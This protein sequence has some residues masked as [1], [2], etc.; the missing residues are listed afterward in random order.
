[1][2]R[3]G[4]LSAVL[5]VGMLGLLLVNA[6]PAAGRLVP[7]RSVVRC[8]ASLPICVPTAFAFGPKGGRLFYTEKDTGQIRVRDLGT[9]KDTVWTTIQGLATTGTQ[10]LLGLALDPTWLQGLE[11]RW[12]YA[13][14]TDDG[15]EDPNTPGEDTPDRNTIVRM[16]KDGSTR[17]TEELLVIPGPAESADNGG[18]L[19][20]G[21][22]GKLYAFAGDGTV[23][24]RAQDL[25][26]PAG[27]V[28]RMNRNGS[29]PSDNPFVGQPGTTKFVYSYGNRNSFGFTFDPWT[30]R[31][32]ETE[33]GP[34]C[35]D[36]INVVV[37]GGN[38]AWGP[39][40]DC[41]SL[42]TPHD[43]NRDGPAPR[44]LPKHTFVET[45]T[46]TGAAFCRGCGLGPRSR[47]DLLVASYKHR[48]ILAF[49]LNPART[50]LSGQRAVFIGDRPPITLLAGPDGRIY[51]SDPAGIRVLR[52]DLAS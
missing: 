46:P 51:F 8:R 9:G 21:P 32:W 23:P 2:G 6:G 30:G 18:P 37:L 42:P 12:V 27:K 24:S 17:I 41:G 29:A 48:R 47:R 49:D 40:H 28:L 39:S 4:V 5:V 1:M 14:Y 38:Y 13:Y 44:I 35:N 45:V 3:R 20:F 7:A 34:E 19:R 11:H 25:A 52:P 26:D 16:R 36:E 22:D 33:N 43:T 31:L 10:G 50:Q 15:L